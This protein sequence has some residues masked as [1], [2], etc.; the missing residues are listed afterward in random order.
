MAMPE[1]SACPKC[2]STDLIPDVKIEDQRRGGAPGE[3]RV[4][5]EEKPDALMFTRPHL[6]SLRATICGRCGFAELFVNDPA[7]LAELLVAYRRRQMESR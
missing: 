7:E 5:I 2:G 6:G 3:L 1:K 4:V